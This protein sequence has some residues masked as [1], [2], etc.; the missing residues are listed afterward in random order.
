MEQDDESSE[1]DFPLPKG[2]TPPD[3]AEPGKEFTALATFRIDEDEPDM[4]CITKIEGV[5]VSSEKSEPEEEGEGQ[6]TSPA[7]MS[8][9]QGGATNASQGMP[10]AATY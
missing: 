6:E 1:V 8:A 5:P 4:I 3:S 7:M 10:A 9:L 2:Y